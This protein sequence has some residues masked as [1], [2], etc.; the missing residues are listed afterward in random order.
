M[1][2]R[3]L[4]WLKRLGPGLLIIALVAAALLSGVEKHLTAGE[5]SLRKDALEA[6]VRLKP[7]STALIFLAA[8]TLYV[9]LCLP[10]LVLFAAL[11]GFLFGLAEGSVIAVLGDTLGASLVFLASK[12]AF[13]DV[14]RRRAGP[15]VAR[16]EQGVSAHGMPYLLAVRFMPAAPFWLINIAAG[17]LSIRLRTF[18]I[19]TALGIYPACLLYS[20]LGARMRRAADRGEPVDLHFFGQP[21]V[22][23]PMI[24]LGLLSIVPLAVIAIRTR[25]ARRAAGA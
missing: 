13:G 7:V 14:L 4:Y 21:E 10:G 12:S 3:T 6:A 5:L 19:A 20:Q 18:V 1:T 11:S 16:L 23:L 8:Y 22:Y 25:R 15:M 9:A 24:G 17:C 2:R